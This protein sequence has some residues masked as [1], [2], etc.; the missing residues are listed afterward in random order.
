M[1][2]ILKKASDQKPNANGKLTITLPSKPKPVQ[3]DD[4]LMVDQT[5]IHRACIEY[6]DA[7]TGGGGCAQGAYCGVYL[8]N[9]GAGDV[10]IGGA[11][12]ESIDLP[13][14]NLLW[15]YN[16]RFLVSLNSVDRLAGEIWVDEAFYGDSVV[17]R[18][19]P[20]SPTFFQVYDPNL[21]PQPAIFYDHGFYLASAIDVNTGIYPQRFNLT[22][23]VCR[24]YQYANGNSGEIINEGTITISIIY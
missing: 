21:P 15:M 12:T 22:K 1:S 23:Y 5:I 7:G 24:I 20:I 4:L 8:F 13:A 3:H 11:G 19:I 9:Y 6:E 10:Y 16:D 18:T 2:Y 14:E 17:S